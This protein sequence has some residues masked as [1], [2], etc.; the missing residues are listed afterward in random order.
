[1][2]TQ[3]VGYVTSSRE[4]LVHLDGLPTIRINDMVE[5]ERG[6]RGWV[7]GIAEDTIEVLMLDEER[8]TPRQRFNS[9]P[10]RLEI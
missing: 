6:A 3:E 10:N 4:F 1:M 8:I 9:A 7:K 2:D 5:S